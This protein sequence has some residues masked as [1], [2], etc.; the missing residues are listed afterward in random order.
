MNLVYEGRK[1][2]GVYCLKPQ[3]R[4]GFSA[5]QL[6]MQVLLLWGQNRNVVKFTSCLVPLYLLCS[7]S[8][9]ELLSLPD[10]KGW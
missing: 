8:I 4:V 10:R 2:K 7:A 5:H 3:T 9:D 1:K 6:K